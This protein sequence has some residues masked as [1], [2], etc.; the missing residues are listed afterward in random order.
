MSGSIAVRS[1]LARGV[2]TLSAPAL[3]GPSNG[4]G[5]VLVGVPPEAVVFGGTD[6]MQSLHRKMRVVAQAN[7]PVLITGENG[8]GKEILARMIH[9]Q[10]PCCDGPFVKVNCPAIP[11]TLLES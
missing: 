4:H 10:S 9:D 11:G 5:T 7:V 1:I 3:V 2:S 8:T 6:R